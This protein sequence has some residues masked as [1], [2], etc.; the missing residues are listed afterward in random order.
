MTLSSKASSA[1]L[2]LILCM[3]GAQATYATTPELSDPPAVD[4]HMHIFSPAGSRVLGLICK[5]LGPAGCPPQRSTASATGKD[6]VSALDEAGIGEG[7]LLSAGYFFGSPEVADQ[8]LDVA[9][10]MRDENAFI[11]DQAK[12][13]CGRLV[14]FVSV[15]PLSPDAVAEIHYWGRKGGAAGLKLHLGS[16]NFDFRDPS[17]VRKLAALYKAAAEEHLAIVM[18]MQTRRKDY[19]AED[20]AIFM[21]DVYP[22][23]RGVPVTIAHAAGGGGVDAGELA[24]LGVF[25]DAIAAHPEA[26]RNLYFDLA[27]VPDLFANEGKIPASPAHVTALE[28]LMRK[29]GLKRFLLGSDYVVGLNLK[30]YYVNEKAA[31]G[32]SDGE[33]RILASN[34]APYVQASTCAAAH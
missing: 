30:A 3:G 27:M 34:V 10:G 28:E 22:M 14:A 8:H 29:I 33:W 1:A 11:V 5:A 18:H 2:A 7:V 24:A 32:L 25:A 15:P 4:H 17:E 13:H 23:A 21:R 16:A 26:T 19:G 6:V 9:K 31:L 20:A 12:A